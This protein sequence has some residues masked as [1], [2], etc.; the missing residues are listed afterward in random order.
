MAGWILFIVQATLLW[1][2]NSQ[3]E[4][5]SNHSLAL[6]VAGV[7]T[8]CVM[9]LRLLNYREN[10]VPGLRL[11]LRQFHECAGRRDVRLVFAGLDS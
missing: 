4:L 6:L 5:F 1:W 8:W 11:P 9:F 2:L 3:W 7:L 10:Q